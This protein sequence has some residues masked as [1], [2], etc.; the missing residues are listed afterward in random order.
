MSDKLYFYFLHVV[1]AAL[2]ILVYVLADQNSTLKQSSAPKSVKIG[3]YFDVS[4]LAN[5]D[6]DTN[7]FDTTGSQLLFVFNTTCPVCSANLDHWKRSYAELS[8]KLTIYGISVDTKQR[9]SEYKLSNS[10]PFPVFCP[11]NDQIETFVNV[12]NVGTVPYTLLR[13]ANGII[14]MSWSGLANFD[15]IHSHFGLISYH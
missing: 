15:Q 1:I 11:E 12:N 4:G 3:Q 8:N 14:E 9:S 6:N 7:K 10:I 2:S 13:N 5:L